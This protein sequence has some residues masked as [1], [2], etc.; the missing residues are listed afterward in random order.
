MN[1]SGNGAWP[2][3]WCAALPSEGPAAC[4]EERRADLR[5][6]AGSSQKL[7]KETKSW[8]EHRFLRCLLWRAKVLI[9][10]AVRTL[11]VHWNNSETVCDHSARPFGVALLIALAFTSGFR[12]SR[13]WERL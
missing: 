1:C 8:P 5:H 2:F 10:F 12:K 6:Q 9:G 13:V 3:A 7:T 4:C 11:W